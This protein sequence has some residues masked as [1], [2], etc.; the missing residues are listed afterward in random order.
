M[1][2]EKP[3]LMTSSINTKQVLYYPPTKTYLPTLQG[4]SSPGR[5]V[6]N[7]EP[8]EKKLLSFKPRPVTNP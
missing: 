5:S 7:E 1:R 6:T 3:S 8:R 2:T 4:R